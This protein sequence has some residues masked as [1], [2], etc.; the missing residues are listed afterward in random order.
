MSMFTADLVSPSATTPRRAERRP[1]SAPA[2]CRRGSSRE[3]VDVLDLS[4]AGA[5]LR[6]VAPLRTGYTIWLKLPGIEAQEARV[7]WTVGFESGC[8]FLRPLYPA[9]FETVAMHARSH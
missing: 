8:E 4:L 5:R 6:A 7:V 1:V 2:Q 3:T 9:V